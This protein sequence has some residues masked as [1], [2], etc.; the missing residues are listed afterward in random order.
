MGDLVSYGK[1]WRTGANNATTITFGDE[2]MVGGTKVPA[3]KYGLVTIPGQDNWTFILTKQLDVTG[4]D[5]YK[6]ENDVV[7]VTAKPMALKDRVETFTMQFA[8]VKPSSCDLQMMWDNTGV[9][10]PITSEVETKVMSQ[11]DN[12]M[13][14]DNRPYFAAAS[15]YFDNG[16]D[17][18]KAKEW[19]QKALDANPKAFWMAHLLAKIQ[20]KAG[21]KAKAIETAK[22]SIELAKEAKNQDYVAL[23]EKLLNTLQ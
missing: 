2:V 19:A 8:N 23:N 4:P 12:L 13:N 18:N 7:R 16:K 14:N 17:L 11:I 20:A 6:Q 3:G 1:I 22:K 9:T 5:G 15:Y 10:L 21:D